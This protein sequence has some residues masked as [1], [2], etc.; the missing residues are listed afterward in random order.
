M[1]DFKLQDEVYWVSQANGFTKRKIG[2]IVDVI[3]PGI[4]VRKSKFSNDLDAVSQPR[5][6]ESYV[7]CLAARPGSRAKPK[8]YWPRV[9]ALRI[10]K[11]S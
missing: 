1:S 8:Y 11:D 9:S 5:D 7:V 2:V 6:H 3:P 4:S 10:H